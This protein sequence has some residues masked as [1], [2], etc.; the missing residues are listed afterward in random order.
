M[1]LPPDPATALLEIYMR[2]WQTYVH[3]KTCI[4]SVRS[5]FLHTHQ[6]REATKDVGQRARTSDALCCIP[7][8]DYYSVRKRKQ[9]STREGHGRYLNM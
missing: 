3:T 7:T 5:G 6:N 4:R 1:L 2:K 9:A 8:V